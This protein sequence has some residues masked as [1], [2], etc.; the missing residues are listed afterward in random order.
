MAAR[1]RQAPVH[2]RVGPG[3]RAFTP[4][5]A[6]ARGSPTGATV[7][8]CEVATPTQIE[9]RSAAPGSMDLIRECHRVAMVDFCERGQAFDCAAFCAAVQRRLGRE[10]VP[11]P[12]FC[13]EKTLKKPEVFRPA[14]AAPLTSQIGL[15]ASTSSALCVQETDPLEAD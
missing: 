12:I 6:H 11:F 15:A 8:N 7:C 9:N 4:A 14:G 5:P 1:A 2:V 10:T 13:A 3:R